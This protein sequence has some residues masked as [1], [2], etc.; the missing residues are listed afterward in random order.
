MHERNEPY[1]PLPTQLKL[2]LIYLPPQKSKAELVRHHSG[3]PRY[4]CA[5]VCLLTRVAQII[6][7]GHRPRDLHLVFRDLLCQ[8]LSMPCCTG[9]L[10]TNVGLSDRHDIY[11][12]SSQ[13]HPGELLCADGRR[14]AALQR[15]MRRRSSLTAPG[16]GRMLARVGHPVGNEKT[17]AGLGFTAISPDCQK[18]GMVHC[19][20]EDCAF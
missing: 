12:L 14:P 6:T 2:V 11:L 15:P 10:G 4:L 7:A 1:L 20:G 9:L 13:D 19:A 16:A 17:W 3:R 8:L 5:R 18:Q